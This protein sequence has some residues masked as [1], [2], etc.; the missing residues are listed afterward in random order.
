[1]CTSQNITRVITSRKIKWAVRVSH[2]RARCAYRI[3]MGKS[4]GR[5]LL[6]RPRRVWK[7]SITVDLKGIGWVGVD[8]IYLTPDVDLW[9][10]VLNAVTKL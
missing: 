7:A 1:M 5:R 3:L 6:G 8:W 2:L 4:K 9:C 10:V